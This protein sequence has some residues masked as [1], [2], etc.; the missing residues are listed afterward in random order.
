APSAYR[1]HAAAG[2]SPAPSV[3]PHVACCSPKRLSKTPAVTASS[4][5]VTSVPATWAA[6]GGPAAPPHAVARTS[7]TVP[8]TSGTR[9]RGGCILEVYEAAGAAGW[10][11]ASPG[12]AG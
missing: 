10:A 1:L 6:A 12:S 9:R 2:V 7:T 4:A 8:R 3:R 5:S 11:T